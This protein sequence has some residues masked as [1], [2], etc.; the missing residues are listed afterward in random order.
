[1]IKF[2]TCKGL[3]KLVSYSTIVTLNSNSSAKCKNW[4]NK[5]VSYSLL[6][7]FG[8]FFFVAICVLSTRNIN[9]TFLFAFQRSKFIRDL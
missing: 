8:T 1:M 3:V 4:T 7:P 9:K 6:I 5:L 2:P